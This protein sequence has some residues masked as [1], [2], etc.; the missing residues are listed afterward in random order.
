LALA[1]KTSGLGLGLGLVL[2]GLGLGLGLDTVGL[3]N[4]TDDFHMY[5]SIFPFSALTLGWVTTDK[6]GIRTVKCRVLF[7]DGDDLTGILHILTSSC[8]HHLHH[9]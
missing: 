8:H 9:P 6:K 3:V 2:P 5:Y 7:L 1:L 4:I